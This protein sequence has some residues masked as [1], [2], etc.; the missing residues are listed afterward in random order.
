MRALTRGTSGRAQV[1]PL[2][3]FVVMVLTGCDEETSAAARQV[4]PAVGVACLGPGGR[5]IRLTDSVVSQL[6]FWDRTKKIGLTDLV[7]GSSSSLLPTERETLPLPLTD[8]ARSVKPSQR[9]PGRERLA[10]ILMTHG[11]PPGDA[12][13][14]I[15]A[16]LSD[17]DAPDSVELQAL[18]W[19]AVVRSPVGGGGRGKRA[20]L[21]T[22]ESKTLDAGTMQGL[23]GYSPNR[24]VYGKMTLKHRQ[25]NGTHYLRLTVGNG[26]ERYPIDDEVE[27]I[28]NAVKGLGFAEPGRHMRFDAE[29]GEQLVLLSWPVGEQPKL[30]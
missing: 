19:I 2:A 3:C 16:A 27:V 18:L 14:A 8:G 5:G 20:R 7:S 15:Q 17:G 24:L 10:G 29:T 12:R 9:H 26:T 21:T 25:S 4:L 22:M 11:C 1:G 6:E 13:G 28:V 23:I 30:F